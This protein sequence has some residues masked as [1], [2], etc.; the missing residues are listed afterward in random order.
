MRAS[1]VARAPELDVH[2]QRAV[3]ARVGRRDPARAPNSASRPAISSAK[4][5]CDAVGC[6]AGSSL[7]GRRRA[8]GDEVADEQL[9]RAT[10]GVDRDRRD[11]VEPQ[12][13]EVGEIVARQRLAAQVRVHEPQAAEPAL[14]RRADGRRRAARSSTR[15]RP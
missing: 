11:R 8:V 5:S 7:H 10:R 1:R 12:Q 3:L 13:R 4:S 15:R 9:A 6:S 2:Q 14:R